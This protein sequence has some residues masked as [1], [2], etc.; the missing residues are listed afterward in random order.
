[1]QAMRNQHDRRIAVN[2]IEKKRP[3]SCE[4]GGMLEAHWALILRTQEGHKSMQVKKQ[5]QWIEMEHTRLEKGIPWFQEP[6]GR[7]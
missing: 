7:K 1:M 4:V 6:L 3:Y 2:E 5:S